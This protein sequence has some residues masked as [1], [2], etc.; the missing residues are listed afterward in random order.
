MEA[1]IF[2]ILKINGTVKVSILYNGYPTR[3]WHS[4]KEPT[5]TT[6]SLE[7]ILTTV[8]IDAHEEHNEMSSGV[9]N[10]SIQTEMP[11]ES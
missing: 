5:I 8:T 7:I 9:P 4:Q 1:L 11:N 6:T 10:Y 2:L 3:D